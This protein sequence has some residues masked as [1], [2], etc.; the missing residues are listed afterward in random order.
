MSALTRQLAAHI[1]SGEMSGRLWLYTNYHC[2]LACTYCLTESSPKVAPRRLDRIRM[3]EI[4][5]QAASLGFT[6]IGLTGGEPFLEPDMVQSIDEIS[7]ILPV[8]VLTNGT[9]FH[10][11]KRLD[12]VSTLA[13]RPV[14]LQISLDHP[15]ADENDAMRGAGNFKRVAL[16]VPK[17]IERGV[18]VRIATTI[19]DEQPE[20][21]Q[22]LDSL[23][24]SWGVRPIDHVRRPIIDRGRAG[25]SGLGVVAPLAALAPELTLT[26]AGS[27][28]TP[29]AP[30]YRDGK[31]QKDLMLTTRIDPLTHPVTALLDVMGSTPREVGE[32]QSGFV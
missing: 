15:D 24:A 18:H 20:N 29:F 23:I 10:T 12:A 19:E 5:K 28:W 11:A 22:R 26:V 25:M 30:T 27:F 32:A 31:L 7:D 3:V 14:R 21:A 1:E 2:N 16:A 4:S 6:G 8:T 17:L 9:L 13:G